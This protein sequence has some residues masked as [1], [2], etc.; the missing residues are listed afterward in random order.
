MNAQEIAALLGGREN[1]E[2]VIDSMLKSGDFQALADLFVIINY[3][4]KNPLPGDLESIEEI[5]IDYLPGFLERN[6]L[7]V[8][9]PIDEAGNSILAHLAI[10]NNK[11]LFDFCIEAGDLRER[12]EDDS[13]KDRQLNNLLMLSV[14]NLFMHGNEDLELAQYLVTFPA[15]FQNVN[16]QGKSVFDIAQQTA[17]RLE[18]NEIFHN[19]YM[20]EILPKIEI[21]AAADAV[22][23]REESPPKRLKDN[24]GQV[25]IMR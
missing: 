19:F 7:T 3:L 23:P 14:A 1:K 25:R 5:F 24:Q 10:A 18:G 21:Q 8:T 16:A 6:N 13:I 15:A 2:V 11:F 17:E 12:L 4:K 9:D 22:E 20:E